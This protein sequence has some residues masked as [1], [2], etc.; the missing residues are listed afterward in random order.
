MKFQEKFKL[1]IIQFYLLPREEGT[2]LK[3]FLILGLTVLRLDR[4][5]DICTFNQR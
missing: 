2:L 5:K 1:F 3:T 4:Q